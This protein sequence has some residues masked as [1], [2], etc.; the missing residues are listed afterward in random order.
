MIKE[1]AGAPVLLLDPLFLQH[2][3]R[4]VSL[5]AKHRLPAMYLARHSVAVTVASNGA[6]LMSSCCPLCRLNLKNPTTE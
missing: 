4:L 6:D 1:R 3:N 2:L 5:A